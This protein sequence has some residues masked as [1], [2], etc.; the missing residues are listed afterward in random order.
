[1]AWPSQR[2]SSG[3]QVTAIRTPSRLRYTS[4]SVKLQDSEDLRCGL[5]ERA[6]S[7]AISSSV[8]CVAPST[9]TTRR[10]SNDAKSTMKPAKITW[11]LKR[12]PRQL[13]GVVARCHRRRSALDRVD[14]ASWG[15]GAH[16]R[17]QS[18]RPV[19]ATPLPN[20]PPQGGGNTPTPHAI[21][22]KRLAR[23]LIL[24]AVSMSRSVI[25]MPASWV[26]NENE[27]MLY[28]LWNSG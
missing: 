24:R 12:K 20:P 5:R 28:E 18:V 8:E 14:V 23:A 13:L 26:Q 21:A 25:F 16:D 11:R 1:M 17:R 4:S 19:G 3:P 6:P 2:S 22:W 10:A 9:S 27:T 15:Q 7:R